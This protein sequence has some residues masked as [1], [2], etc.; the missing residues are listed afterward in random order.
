MNSSTIVIVPLLLSRKCHDF[1]T[2]YLFSAVLLEDHL[3]LV[4]FTSLFLEGY[5]LVW[6]PIKLPAAFRALGCAATQ[7]LRRWNAPDIAMINLWLKMQIF[8][9]RIWCQKTRIKRLENNIWSTFMTQS[10][11]STVMIL[12]YI[13]QNI[14]NYM[15]LLS[16]ANI[17]NFSK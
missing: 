6:M 4:W 2:S 12:N 7:V 9:F 17:K 3:L 14:I 5:A 1:L 8:S 16:V 13:L 15:C 10:S 11:I